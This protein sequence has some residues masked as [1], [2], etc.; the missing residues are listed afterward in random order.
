MRVALTGGRFTTVQTLLSIMSWNP[1][2]VI[3]PTSCPGSY[4]NL[5]LPLT[6]SLS[7]SHHV[8][9][10]IRTCVRDQNPCAI[11]R[12][13]NSMPSY[14]LSVL[15]SFIVLGPPD[16]KYL[17]LFYVFLGYAT[18][19]P[20]WHPVFNLSPSSV[21]CSVPLTYDLA[22]MCFLPLMYGQPWNFTN[23]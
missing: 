14:F 13:R 9:L 12:R 4:H 19:L 2:W 3:T 15:Y 1:V 20:T 7:R 5:Q 16:Y 21:P 6:K 8:G 17:N 22:F 11:T 10:L 18:P 23:V